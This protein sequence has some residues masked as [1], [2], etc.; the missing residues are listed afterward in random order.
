MFFKNI[1]VAIFITLASY[2]AGAQECEWLNAGLGLHGG[3]VYSYA[4]TTDVN[5]NSFVA[6]HFGDSFSAGPL[7]FWA[8]QGAF[9]IKYN[10]TGGVAWGKTVV[11]TGLS[12][13]QRVIFTDIITDASG[14]IYISG[15]NIGEV[16]FGN[17][18][19]VN[20]TDSI[21]SQFLVKYN[22][23]GQVQWVNEI[24][25]SHFIWDFKLAV[26]RQANIIM[27]GI[28][29]DTITFKGTSVSFISPG[30]FVPSIAVVKYTSAGNFINAV[31]F[32]GIVDAI[33]GGVD[34]D[35]AGNIYIAAISAGI[36]SFSFGMTTLS[37]KGQV[38][39]KL[40]P[41]LI[42][43]TGQITYTGS[44][45]VPFGYNKVSIAVKQSGYFAVTGLF[46]GTVNFGNGVSLTQTGTNSCNSNSYITYY[47]P[48][49]TPQW[50]RKDTPQVT[51]FVS[52]FGG[53]KIKGDYIFLG[54]MMGEGD[55]RFGNILLTDSFGH[56]IGNPAAYLVKMD[57]LGNFLWAFANTATA[58]PSGVM[59]IAVDENG[60]PYIIGN[61]VGGITVFNKTIVNG[62][63][64]QSIKHFYLARISDYTISR[65]PVSNGPYCAGDTV[66][67]P[68]SKTGNYRSDNEFIAELSDSAGNFTGDE[69]ELGRIAATTGDTIKGVL[70][71]FNVVTN[72]RYRIRIM[73]TQPP[74]QSFYM[75]DN[76]RLLIYS[77]DTA[78]AGPDITLC[79]GQTVK[80][81]TTG[82]S[83]WRWSPLQYLPNP[84][85]AVTRTPLV[86]PE[87]TI[88]YRIVISDTSGCG[89]TD[90][91][92]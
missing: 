47:A 36:S 18:I 58:G 25:S 20:H 39:L 38:L 89:V 30:Q 53:I 15:T 10:D 21:D 54:G 16:D 8:R 34:C 40:S 90:T 74:V 66:Y 31:K 57:T 27:A 52:P 26:D 44:L 62:Y 29:R 70:P 11:Q 4:V 69:R 64:F 91:D 45:T 79:R 61:W 23:A 35:G 5:N 82:G 19:K 1:W 88:T 63:P 33:F 80:L 12:T 17:G 92:F 65:G 83:K 85:D 68:Y 51:G 2:R 76:L 43:V 32:G 73:S 67:I 22:A 49:L 28:F 42:P 55:V 72:N 7:K 86:K 50:A 41:S 59:K 13:R 78:N 24:N 48:D 77:K 37:G 9:I 6:G 84:F 75:F 56:T 46:S 81:H 87:Q 60:K 14:N 3:S 71:L